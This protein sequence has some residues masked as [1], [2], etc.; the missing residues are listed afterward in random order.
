MN[1]IF[2]C[3][4]RLTDTDRKTLTKRQ[5]D[6]HTGQTDKQRQEEPLT[7]DAAGWRRR[8]RERKNWRRKEWKKRRK[9]KVLSLRCSREEDEDEGDDDEDENCRFAS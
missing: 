8:S 9:R 4:H 2:Q 3:V 5:T 7:W 6:K 1:T